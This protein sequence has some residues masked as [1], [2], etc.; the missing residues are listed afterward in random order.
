MP[1]RDDPLDHYDPIRLCV[2]D[3]DQ[4]FVVTDDH[5]EVIDFLNRCILRAL[6]TGSRAFGV[7]TPDSDWDYVIPANLVSAFLRI[8]MA[9]RRLVLPC[10]YYA[11]EDQEDSTVSGRPVSSR[12]QF[13]LYKYR[14]FIARYDIIVPIT[15]REYYAWEYATLQCKSLIATAENGKNLLSDKA[16]R[17]ELFESYKKDYR[18][19]YTT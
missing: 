4:Y 7:N 9:H 8:P 15:S 3:P 14:T 12:P 18:N 2:V 1:S 16:I 10:T 11:E 17:V 13:K 19:V 5:V 6:H